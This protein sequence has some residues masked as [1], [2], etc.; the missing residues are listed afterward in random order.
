MSRPVLGPTLPPVQ[1]YWGSLQGIKQQGHEV[2]LS[3]LSTAEVKN[4]W[5]CASSP[6]YAFVAL[7]ETNV[8]FLL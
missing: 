2:D 7:R 5:N 6:P 8:P 3:P 4:E 1:S